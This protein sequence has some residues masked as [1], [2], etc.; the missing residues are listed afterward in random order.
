V[1]Q[2]KRQST[3]LYG[4]ASQAEGLDALPFEAGLQWMCPFAAVNHPVIFL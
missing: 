4:F 2:Q 3:V 1:K